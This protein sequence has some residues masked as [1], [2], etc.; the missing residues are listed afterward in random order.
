MSSNGWLNREAGTPGRNNKV[1]AALLLLLAAAISLGSLGCGGAARTADTLGP[2]NTLVPAPTPGPAPNPA[3]A[4]AS[5]S[6]TILTA[7]G[8]TFTLTVNGSNFVQASVVRWNGSSR[9]TTFVNSGQLT[10][11]ISASD[12][13][14]ASQAAV[15]VFNPSPGGGTSGALAFTVL[16]PIAF[17]SN[18][19]LDGSNTSATAFN[20]WLSQGSDAV[21]LTKLTASN[22]DSGE[23]AWS[24]DGRKIAFVSARALDGS[25]APNTNRTYNIWVVNADGSGVA[26][27]TRLTAS[28][29]NCDGPT[30][31]PDG[32]KIAFTSARALD[33]TDNATLGAPSNLWVIN[34]DGSG[35]LPLTSLTIKNADSSFPRWSPDGSKIAFVS[36][37]ALDGGNTNNNGGT[38]N[39]WTIKA[40]GSGAIPLTKLTA[41][42]GSGDL[43]WSPDSS[44]I[45]FDSTRALDGS[46]AA[47]A[48]QTAN[49]W[50]INADGSA[51]TAL[52]RLTAKFASSSF[53]VWSPNGGKIVFPSRRALDGSDAALANLTA[54]IW[55][56]NAD[57]SGAVP[58][59]RF[60]AASVY[61]GSPEWS[62]DGSRIVFISDSALDGSDALN[63]AVN[64]WV[65]NPD[66]TGAIPL[67]RLNAAGADSEYPQWQ[68]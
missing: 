48:N 5:I 62:P 67:T 46:D 31:S 45:A 63:N 13:A 32:S 52:T 2:A 61:P 35:D 4:V 12:L 15:T 34:A 42:T 27:L 51:L 20:I 64:L 33:G 41:F 55:V 49:I 29:A 59:T 43:M 26:P 47:N 22:V 54:N 65:M 57:G 58:L 18:R 25:D 3:P 10:A 23:Q 38:A 60:T 39:L 66:G 7:Q 50:V 24:P 16:P 53:P 21:P 17:D 9:A 37:R 11:Q 36:T 19:T 40:D 68:P 44:K 14:T 1:F 56:M 30:W 6:P 28:G 8:P